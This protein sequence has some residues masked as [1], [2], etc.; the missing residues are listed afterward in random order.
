MSSK[1]FFFI[2]GYNSGTLLHKSKICIIV[3]YAAEIALACGALISLIFFSFSNFK[4]IL[5]RPVPALKTT[6][7][8]FALSKNSLSTFVLL[9]III[10]NVF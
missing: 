7:K 2:F 5:S 6:F 1:I 10:P 4:S 3:S 9:F 8:F